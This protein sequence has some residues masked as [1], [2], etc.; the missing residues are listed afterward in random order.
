MDIYKYEFEYK[1]YNSDGL[2]IDKGIETSKGYNESIAK[3]NLKTRLEEGCEINEN[4]ELKLIP[5]FNN[6]Y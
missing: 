5:F 4:V 6:S 1:V 2:E 3:N